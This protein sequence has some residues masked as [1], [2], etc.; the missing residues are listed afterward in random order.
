VAHARENVNGW[1]SLK[2]SLGRPEASALR[3]LLRHNQMGNASEE[4]PKKVAITAMAAMTLFDKPG[5]DDAG[6]S[7]S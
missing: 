2:L 6:A 5:D 3:F 1:I 7:V 4:R